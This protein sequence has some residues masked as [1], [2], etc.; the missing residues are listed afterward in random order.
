MITDPNCSHCKE[1]MSN[2]EELAFEAKLFLEMI[3]YPVLGTKSRDMSAHAICNDYSYEDY[4]GMTGENAMAICEKAD[5]L[6]KKT[7]DLFKLAQISF[8]PLVVASD[9]SWVVEGNDICKVRTHLGLETQGDET[10][11]GKGCAAQEN[12]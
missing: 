10:G 2:L 9:G 1:L 8:V 3:I 6:I 4:Q 7:N 5:E 12:Q 11:S